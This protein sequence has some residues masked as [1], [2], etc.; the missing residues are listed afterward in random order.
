MTTT[1]ERG[2]RSKRDVKTI[3]IAGGTTPAAYVHALIGKP[4]PR[5]GFLPTAGGDGHH[6]LDGMVQRFPPDRWETY[7]ISLFRRTIADLRSFML[8]CDAIWVAGGNAASMLAVWRVHGVDEIL[9]ECWD[10]GVV[11]GGS[12]A[13]SLCWFEGGTTDSF[14][15]AKLAPLRDGLGFLPGTHSPH[16]DSEPQRRPLYHELIAGGFPGGVACDDMAVVRYDG[17]EID[18][19]RSLRDGSDAYRVELRDGAVVE[20]PLGAKPWRA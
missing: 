2:A 20:T 5:L 16:Y 17:T 1:A 9:R 6:Y 8:G 12:S 3:V 18:E 14:D 4:R 10:A 19:V 11:L 15:L 13:G 7:W